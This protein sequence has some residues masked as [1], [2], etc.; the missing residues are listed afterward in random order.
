MEY[1]EK[2]NPTG[3][4]LGYKL[5]RTNPRV[6]QVF[7]TS[8]DKQQVGRTFKGV[9]YHTAKTVLQRMKNADFSSVSENPGTF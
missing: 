8:R 4:D 9:E 1:V 7:G 5:L 2:S 6:D 3:T